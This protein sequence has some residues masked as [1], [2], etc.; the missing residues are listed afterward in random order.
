VSPNP[1][2]SQAD[3]LATV[4]AT[5]PVAPE[6]RAGY[7]RTLFR[8]W[9]DADHDG[10]NTRAEVLIEEAIVAPT[11]AAGC[12]LS[13]GEWFSAYDGR[14]FTNASQLDIDHLVPLAEAW[15]SGAFRWSAARRQAYANDLGVPWALVAVSAASNRSK[16]DQDPAAWLPPRTQATCGYL[17]D[18]V[19]V[20]A[21][22]GLS[23][24]PAEMSAIAGETDC[25]STPV[26]VVP[27]PP[28]P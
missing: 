28:T 12:R 8:L 6:E 18:W 14:R 26:D 4:L 25:R 24:D 5:L 9:I 3:T 2:A 22:W 15:D 13:G 20:K 1:S 7:A 27:A 16:G 10:C 23:V 19:A 21:R 17:A 11:V